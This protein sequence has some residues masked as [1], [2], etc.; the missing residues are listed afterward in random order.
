MASMCITGS[1]NTENLLMRT[2]GTFCVYFLTT[3]GCYVLLQNQKEMGKFCKEPHKD[4]PCRILVPTRRVVS[5][6]N[7]E[8]S[9]DDNEKSQ[10]Q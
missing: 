7:N 4:Y 5:D 8:K 6:D 2:S 9:C 10:R 3:C 1:I